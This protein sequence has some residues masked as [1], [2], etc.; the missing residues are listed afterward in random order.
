LYAWEFEKTGRALNVRVEGQLVF[1]SAGFLLEG[2]LKGLGLA[3]LTEP[4]G[5]PRRVRMSAL[6]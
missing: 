6:K 3:Y 2:A 5:L 1:N 4:G